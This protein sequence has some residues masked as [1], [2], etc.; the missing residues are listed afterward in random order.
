MGAIENGDPTGTRPATTDPNSTELH[1]Q[2][3]DSNARAEGDRQQT[4]PCL[5]EPNIP[6]RKDLRSVPRRASSPSDVKV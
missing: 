3:T 1:D 5:P 4:H 6:I 2:K